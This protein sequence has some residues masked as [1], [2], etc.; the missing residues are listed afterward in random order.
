MK[1]L[2]SIYVILLIGLISCNQT[3]LKN[4]VFTEKAPKPIGPYSQA[5]TT[6]DF[7]FVSGQIAINPTDNKLDTTSI[8]NQTKVVME[9]IKN[10]LEAAQSDLNRVVKTTV[11]I[12]DIKKFAEFNKVYSEYFDSIPPARETVEVSAL[13]KNAGIEISVI[14]LKK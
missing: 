11:F 14:A 8:E 12:K 13:P 7:I 9:N 4:K 5:I 6:G 2:H 1:Y 10:I 3:E